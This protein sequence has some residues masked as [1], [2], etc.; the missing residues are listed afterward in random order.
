MR[1][2]R[3]RRRNRQGERGRKKGN[4]IL[5]RAWPFSSSTLP[6]CASLPLTSS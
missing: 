3:S 4:Y 5:K 2:E 1:E 6:V